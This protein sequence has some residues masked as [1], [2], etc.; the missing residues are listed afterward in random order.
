MLELKNVNKYFHRGKKNQ[1]HVI[2][3]TSLKLPDTG[4]VALLGPSGCGKTTLLNAIGGLDKIK[5]GTITIDSKKISTRFTSKVDKI[6]NL[7]IGYI[8][9]DYKLIDHLSVYDNVAIV[10]KMLGIKNKEEIKRRVEYVLDCVG[11]LRYQRRPAG[12]LSGGERQRVGI[13][14]AIVKN[15]NIILA[16][17]P[18]GNLDSKNTLEIMKIIKA[19]SKNRLVILVTHEQNLATFYADR[20]IR[21]ADGKILS[22]EENTYDHD[23]DYE[24]DNCF[25]LKDFKK[26]NTYQEKNCCISLYQNEEENISLDMVVR[27]GNV[28][29]KSNNSLSVEVVDDTSNIEFIDG[30]Y[31]KIGKEHL[32]EYQ[33]DFSKIDNHRLKKKYASIMNPFS[34]LRTGF[35]KVLNYPL[36][37]KF[38]FI[39]FFLAGLFIMYSTSS[40]AATL[41]FHQEDFIQSDPHYLIIEKGKNTD[42][43]YSNYQNSPDVLY[44]LPGKSE[45]S[46]Q[47]LVKDYYQTLDFN[48]GKLTGSLVSLSM[49][50]KSDLIKGKMPTNNREIV[51]DQLVATRLM[52]AYSSYQMVGIID[53]DD[54]LGR[55]VSV[56]HLGDFKIVGI[57]NQVSP[58]IYVAQEMM[59]PIILNSNLKNDSSASESKDLIAYSLYQDKITIKK[60]RAPIN[61]NE[62]IVNI[63]NESTMPLNKEIKISEHDSRVVVGYYTSVDGYSYYFTTDKAIL[64]NYLEKNKYLAIY[65]NHEKKVLS[66]FQEK[67]V[68]IYSSY[69]RS[70]KEYQEKKKEN[71]KTTL[72]VSGIILAISFIEIFL[73]IRSSFLSRVKEIGIY[74]AIGIKITDIYLM[75]SGEIIAITTLVEIPGLLLMAYIL[76]V[77]SKVKILSK[78]IFISPT[79][80]LVS[81]LLVYLFNLLFG[82]F[83]IYFT[84]RKRPAEILSRYDVD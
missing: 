27:N 80:I 61:D 78:M 28:Y 73:M 5:S 4:L 16:D 1:I 20:I 33:F 50:K 72:I 65:T 34:S 68:N 54:F 3:H 14:R 74:R 22:D 55:V 70:L 59:V 42:E 62:I 19:I 45:V 41:Q 15:P 36:L 67:K 37:K 53:I 44:V 79:L 21:I 69:D 82:L 38:L 43:D 24:I 10:L 60:G 31:Q 81:I 66:T 17:E 49:L 40:I 77:L 23:L 58:N 25:Y 30:H 11:M 57:T 51:I 64:S 2:D 71:R 75:F 26:K 76:D 29:I 8:F 7:Y 12:M 13:A 84:V 46:F 63:N 35:L 18:T 47:F 56:N 9:Q 6:R 52:N 48:D 39:G 32:N 83:P